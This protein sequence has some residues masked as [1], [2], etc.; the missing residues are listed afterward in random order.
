MDAGTSDC[1]F[2]LPRPCDLPFWRPA[3]GLLDFLAAYINPLANMHRA[4]NEIVRP[5][6]SSVSLFASRPCHTTHKT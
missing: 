2:I 1:P 3:S 5:G 4:R 6:A